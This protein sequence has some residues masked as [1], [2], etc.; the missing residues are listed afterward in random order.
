[1]S[2]LGSPRALRQRVSVV[3]SALL[4]V[5][6]FAGPLAVPV[7]GEPT[8]ALETVQAYLDGKSSPLESVSEILL[9]QGVLHRVD[10]RLIIAIAG[11][12]TTFGTRLCGEFNAWNWFWCRASQ[13]Q[14]SFDDR[15][16]ES[17]FESWEQGV[18]IVTK[19]MRKSYLSKGYTTIVSMSRKY[20]GDDCEDW[21][22]NVT[23][24]Y[25]DELSGDVTDFGYSV[26]GTS[27]N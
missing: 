16:V 20:C 1:M 21:T 4:A 18:E 6:L 8:V 10:P 24:F 5:A 25:S 11:A 3:S 22:S 26:T 14:C 2:F 15:C 9:T 13:P 27:A 23:R 17:P 7:G 19:F 12:E